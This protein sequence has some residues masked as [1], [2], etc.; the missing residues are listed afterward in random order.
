[1][2]KNTQNIRVGIASCLKAILAGVGVPP[3]SRASMI[4]RAQRNNMT[5]KHFEA[6][7][8]LLRELS[9]SEGTIEVFVTFFQAHNPL[10]NVDRFYKAVR[11]E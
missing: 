7:A 3:D 8:K 2:V 1:M 5:R 6:A 9:A 10:F 11:G 4:I